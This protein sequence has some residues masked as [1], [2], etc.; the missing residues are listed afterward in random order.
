[1]QMVLREFAVTLPDFHQAL[2]P[3]V[4]RDGSPGLAVRL[5]PFLQSGIPKHPLLM[6]ERIETLM[7][8]T[9]SISSVRKRQHLIIIVMSTYVIPLQFPVLHVFH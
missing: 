2:A 3:V 5:D 8:R 6:Q 7:A 1:M 9:G 4:E